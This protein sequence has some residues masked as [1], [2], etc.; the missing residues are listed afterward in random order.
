MLGGI[1]VAAMVTT[2]AMGGQFEG[3]PP[4]T[5][6]AIFGSF[7]AA[8]TGSV[9]PDI[10]QPTSTM[11]RTLPIV[12]KMMCGTFGHRGFCHSLLFLI[13][14]YGLTAAFLPSMSF[15]ALM[16]CFGAASHLFF[17]MFNRPGVPLLWPFKLRFRLAKIKTE[18]KFG[19][20]RDNLQEKI[21]RLIVAALDVIL[22]L[23]MA[24]SIW[25]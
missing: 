18:S 9:F 16:L 5:T 4:L 24:A 2:V 7:I 17:D 10:D 12:S 11:G 6:P 1:A 8:M 22:I 19:T 14:I 21:F 3:L 25:G 13:V 20:K 23:S 15:Y